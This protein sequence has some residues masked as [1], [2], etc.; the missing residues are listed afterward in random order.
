M[1]QGKRALA[2]QALKR[3]ADSPNPLQRVDQRSPLQRT[4]GSSGS[5]LGAV[6]T[7]G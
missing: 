7:S 2:S 5:P 3:L 6:L 4:L 1:R